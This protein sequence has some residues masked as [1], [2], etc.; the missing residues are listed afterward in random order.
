MSEKDGEI[1]RGYKGHFNK[2]Y[3]I[4]PLGVDHYFSGEGW[5][6]G[7]KNIEQNCLQGLKRQNKLHTNTICVKK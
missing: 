6:G 2:E 5:G 1:R 7:M 4:F 3:S